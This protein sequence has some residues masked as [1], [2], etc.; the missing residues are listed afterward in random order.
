M[1]P[2]QFPAL[3]LSLGW[4]LVGLSC[5]AS[6]APGPELPFPTGWDKLG[7]LVAY[8]VLMTWFAGIY[9]RKR[10]PIVAAGLLLLGIGIEF[11]QRATGY[12]SF[13]LQ[14]MLANGAGI[15]LGWSIALMFVGGWCLQV[16]T[17]FTRSKPSSH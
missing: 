10:Y 7:H 6:L 8:L 5:A 16:E 14:D 12:R 13:E 4:L 15:V 17:R 3:W 11:V 2:L 9:E 1:L